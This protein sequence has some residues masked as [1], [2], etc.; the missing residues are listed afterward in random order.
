MT[1][2]NLLPQ[3][4]TPDQVRIH[5]QNLEE[6][7]MRVNGPST[8]LDPTEVGAY[9]QEIE[10]ETRLLM[11]IQAL[12]NEKTLQGM[13]QSDL[14]ESQVLHVRT[15]P[16]IE[17]S[18]ILRSD[19][20]GLRVV[21]LQVGNLCLSVRIGHFSLLLAQAAPEGVPVT[22]SLEPIIE[23]PSTPAPTPEAA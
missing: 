4:L 13:M 15:N 16:P 18:G 20:D 10:H 9:I 14:R 8:D 6:E 23:L 19:N 1:V 21:Q 2:T 12:Q 5:L 7:L 11:Q 17:T 3:F 22:L